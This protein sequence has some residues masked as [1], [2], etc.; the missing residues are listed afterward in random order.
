LEE[1]P[2]NIANGRRLS[3]GVRI[4]LL[5]IRLTNCVILSSMLTALFLAPLQEKSSGPQIKTIVVPGARIEVTLPDRQMKVSPAEL[6]DWASAAAG[7]VS[8]YYGRFPVPHLFLKIRA[9]GGSRIRHGVTYAKDGGL[10]LITVGENTDVSELNGDWMLTHEMIHLAFPSMA[11]KH[12]WIEEGISTYVEP[13][14]RVQAGRISAQRMWYEFVRDIPKG[15][16]QAGDRGLDNTPTWGRTYWGGALFCL[17]ADVEI[18][19]RTDN[20]LGLQ[21]AL[22]GILNGG[23]NIGED[24]EIEKALAMGDKATGTRVLQELY[25]RR[26]NTPAPVDL[27]EL[28]RKLGVELRDG[29]IMFNDNASEAAIRRAI[30]LPRAADGKGNSSGSGLRERQNNSSGLNR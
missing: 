3:G 30:T 10:I 16:P 1:S 18:R 14:A 24:W 25:G 5:G 7:A 28:W 21:D 8:S 6:L 4:P 17:A 27:D 29:I 19:E 12:H 15:L 23:G 2:K 22:R 9:D 26:R 20:H 11:D 13:V